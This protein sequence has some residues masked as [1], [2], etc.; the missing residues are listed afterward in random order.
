MSRGQLA[1]SICPEGICL[2]GNWQ[3]AFVRRAIGGGHLSGGHLSG[4][5]LSGLHFTITTTKK[6][7]PSSSI[8]TLV[9]GIILF[10]ECKAHNAYESYIV[11]HIL[12]MD[13]KLI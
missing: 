9:R 13:L 4:G 12:S 1:E 6:P 5:D 10:N 8:I 3:R 11:N 7:D 2:E